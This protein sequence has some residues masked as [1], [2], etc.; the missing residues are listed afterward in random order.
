MKKIAVLGLFFLFSC[1]RINTPG[2]E[3][4]QKA[5]PN[6]VLY[7]VPDNARRIIGIDRTSGIVFEIRMSQGTGYSI[8]EIILLERHYKEEQ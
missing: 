5:H 8:S 1:S 3:A 7:Y 2:V 4:L 6:L